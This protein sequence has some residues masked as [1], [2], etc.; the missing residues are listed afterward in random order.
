MEVNAGYLDIFKNAEGNYFYMFIGLVAAL[1]RGLDLPTY[2]LL[3]G[4]VFEG[5]SFVPYDGRMMHRFAMA[6]IAFCSA[7][8][9]IW[10]FQTVSVSLKINQQPAYI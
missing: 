10:F 1:I 7:G 5:F 9:G 3:F 4:W 6:V 2:A 8:V